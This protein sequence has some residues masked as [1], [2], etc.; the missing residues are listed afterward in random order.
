MQL[1]D[2]IFPGEERVHH[3]IIRPVIDKVKD[4]IVHHTDVLDTAKAQADTLAAPQD[5]TDTVQSVQNLACGLVSD[6]GGSSTL[7]WTIVIVGCALMLCLY[8]ALA[9]RK[10]MAKG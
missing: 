5:T 2:V 9:Y 1:L 4:T 10:R 6:N 3:P 8:F 7:L